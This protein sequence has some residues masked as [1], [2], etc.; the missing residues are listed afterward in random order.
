MLCLDFSSSL[1]HLPGMN[2][3]SAVRSLVVRSVSAEQLSLLGQQL[4]ARTEEGRLETLVVLDQ[5][6]RGLPSF[7]DFVQAVPLL[8]NFI[9]GGYWNCLDSAFCEAFFAEVAGALDK[10]RSRLQSLRLLG[11]GASSLLSIPPHT[12]H[13]SIGG[14]DREIEGKI[15]GIS[16]QNRGQKRGISKQNRGQN[17][18]K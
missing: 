18:P 6:F 1:L 10:G 14:Q 9:V 13:I 2:R 5:S 12:G 8:K 3:F 17:Q 15:G 16:G 7:L 4:G 11:L